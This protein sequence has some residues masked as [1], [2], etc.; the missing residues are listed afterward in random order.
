[1]VVNY[2]NIKR[3]TITPNEADAILIVDAN[4]V[5]PFPI[6][7]QSFKVIPRKDCKIAQHVRGV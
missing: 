4:A 5:L 3:I 7:F 2:L 1:M 6:S